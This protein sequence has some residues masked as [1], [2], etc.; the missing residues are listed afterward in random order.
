MDNFI[1]NNWNVHTPYCV[2]SH[3]S[4]S[5]KVYVGQTKKKR[6]H[7]RWVNGQGY[8][9][10]KI[11]YNAIQKYGWENF[12]H[13]IIKE[14]L[15]K[16]EADEL[17]ISLIQNYKSKNISYNITDGGGG[18]V[19]KY[20]K[21]RKHKLSESQK[22]RKYIHKNNVEK[23][24]KVEEISDYLKEG[25]KMG[26]RADWKEQCKDVMRQYGSPMKGKKHTEETIKK[27]KDSHK[28]FRPTEEHKR[29]TSESL[30]GRKSPTTGLIYI[31]DGVVDKMITKD[32]LNNYIKDGWKRGRSFRSPVSEFCKLRVSETFKNTIYVNNGE[33]NKRIKQELLEK[34]INDGWT[35]GYLKK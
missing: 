7:D 1:Q 3:T 20:T 12:E 29:K 19:V 30:K 5:G 17:E 33:V 24:V 14:G 15:T 27:M 34:Y 28:N 11:F 8:L 6:L 32:E 9:T 23:R 13:K 22:G 10:C 31:T 21:E 2:Y 25:W 35:K 16:N 18:C 26:R 4:P